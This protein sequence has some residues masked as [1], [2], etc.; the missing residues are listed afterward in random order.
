MN[1]HTSP[2]VDRAERF[3]PLEVDRF[4]VLLNGREVLLANISASGLGCYSP[5]DPTELLAQ[6]TTVQLATDGVLVDCGPARVVRV[7]APPGAAS[8]IAWF[9]GIAFGSEQSDVLDQLLSPPFAFAGEG[10]SLA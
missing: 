9:V 7:S 4:H 5:F 8:A 10:A 1:A 2:V 3:R 6:S